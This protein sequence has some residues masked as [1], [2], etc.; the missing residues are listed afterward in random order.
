MY[1]KS[2]IALTREIFGD[3][4]CHPE[5]SEG[6]LRQ[7]RQILRFAQDDSQNLSQVRLW[8]VLSLNVCSLVSHGESAVGYGDRNCFAGRLDRL[9][10][11]PRNVALPHHV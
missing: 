8:V 6:S 3:N 5:R 1:L 11:S 7:S 4:T 9:A 2:T 10:L